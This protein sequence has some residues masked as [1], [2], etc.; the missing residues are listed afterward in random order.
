MVFLPRGESR[1]TQ[2]IPVNTARV[3]ELLRPFLD[4]CRSE[5]RCEEKAAFLSDRQLR[6]ISTYIDLL[7]RWNARINLTAIRQPEEIVTRHFGESL[8][9]ARHLFPPGHPRV[10]TGVLDCPAEQNPASREEHSMDRARH[11]AVREG[12]GFSRANQLPEE[13]GSAAEVSADDRRPQTDDVI[14][15][16]SGAGFPG[17]P[18]KLWSPRISLTL[19]ESNQKKVALLREVIRALTLMN[20][21]VFPGRA[22]DFERQA[23]V[24]TLRAVERFDFVLSTAASLV[25]PGGRLA[26]LIGQAQVPKT[27]TF[28][29]FTWQAPIP[30]PLSS[31][32]ALLIG[33]RA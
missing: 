27:M 13:A 32:R 33:R 30:I 6:D 21:H 1:S 14:D 20:T 3:A 19:I 12:H 18:I 9:A 28:R 16:G 11:L 23:D 17:L 5:K 29:D 4:G 10:G 31:I 22:Q 26:L 24:V 15:I 2:P 8:F 25:A 7:L